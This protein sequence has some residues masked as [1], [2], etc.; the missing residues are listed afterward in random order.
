MLHPSHT[1]PIATLPQIIEAIAEPEI[2]L[3]RRDNPPR[4]LF[5]PFHILGTQRIKTGFHPHSRTAH[6][7]LLLDLPISSR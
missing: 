1:H 5:Q 3:T 7:Q 2:M 4:F 6:Q